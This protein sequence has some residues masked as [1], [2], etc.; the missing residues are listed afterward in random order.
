MLDDKEWTCESTLLFG[1]R[2]DWYLRFRCEVIEWQKKI[3]MKNA[4]KHC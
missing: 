1:N 3:P 2:S 4:Q